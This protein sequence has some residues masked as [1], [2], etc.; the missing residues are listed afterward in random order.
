MGNAF[1]L[2]HYQKRKN[3]SSVN[4]LPVSHASDHSLEKNHTGFLK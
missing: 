4:I 2:S 3:E 1:I